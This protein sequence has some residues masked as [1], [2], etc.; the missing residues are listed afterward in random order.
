MTQAAS[1]QRLVSVL[2]SLKMPESVPGL[3]AMLD[4]KEMQS[5][6]V[7]RCR[8]VMR[9][10]RSD[11]AANAMKCDVAPMPFNLDERKFVYC[12]CAD[13]RDG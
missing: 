3:I 9:Q 12:E 5:F 7:G 1:R 8:E 2:Q 6:P 10:I 4:E 11:R 13:D